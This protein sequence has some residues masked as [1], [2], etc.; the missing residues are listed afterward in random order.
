MIYI[1]NNCII[2]IR[3]L[4]L[5]ILLVMINIVCRE[6]LIQICTFICMLSIIFKEDC[7]N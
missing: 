6:L 2:L 4:V 7:K 5:F 1:I 3:Y